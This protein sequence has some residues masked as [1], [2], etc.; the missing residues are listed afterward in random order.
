[1]ASAED[2]VAE[3]LIL[4]EWPAVCEQVAA[5]AATPAGFAAARSQLPLGESFAASSHL[6][7]DE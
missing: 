2:T 6:L 1:M 7:R 4:L 5:F 3:S